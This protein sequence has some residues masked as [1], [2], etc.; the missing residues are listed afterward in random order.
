MLI[1]SVD[2]QLWDYGSKHMQDLMA[3]NEKLYRII[4]ILDL[5]PKKPYRNHAQKI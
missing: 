4:L 2:F 5:S 1:L 3:L